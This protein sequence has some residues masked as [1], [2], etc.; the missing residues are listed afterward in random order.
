MSWGFVHIV[1][2]P[3]ELIPG[4]LRVK[5]HALNSET[6]KALPWENRMLGSKYSVGII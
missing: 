4:P 2:Y 6:S 5:S 3:D 1:T